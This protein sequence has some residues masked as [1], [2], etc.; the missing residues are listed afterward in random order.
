MLID[1]ILALY[2]ILNVLGK[3]GSNCKTVGRDWESSKFMN[4]KI[5]KQNLETEGTVLKYACL[6]N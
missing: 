6:F 4:L 3:F 5:H 2:D 1:I